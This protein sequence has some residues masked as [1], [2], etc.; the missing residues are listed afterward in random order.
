M[1]CNIRICPLP[2]LLGLAAVLA[3]STGVKAI[4]QPEF[5]Y[6]VSDELNLL[7]GFSSTAPGTLGSAVSLTGLAPGEQIRAIDYIGVTL[8][9]LGSEGHLYT[10]N[11]NTGAATAVGS[12]FSVPLNGVNFG[13][14]EASATGPLYVASDLGQNLRV[15]PTTGVATVLPGYTGATLDTLSYNHINNTYL[16]VSAVTHDL[17]SVNPVTGAETLI[18]A[19]GV[20]F[21][22]RI[23][24]TVSLDLPAAYFSGTIGG[25][26]GFYDLNP[27]T[28]ALA[29]VGDIGAPG[30]FTAGLDSITATGIILI[31]EPAAEVLLA[32]GGGFSL[33][34][35]RRKNRAQ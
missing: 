23:G 29:F 3:A 10:V 6:G 17:Y 22:D 21:L 34:L 35:L 18:G 14:A 8:Y 13:I 27:L 30:E 12:T 5:I 28:G 31:P 16:G 4:A 7:V 1:L 2:P 32:V 9:G 20:N 26:T 19:T 15:N 33:F 25:Q 11:P 24:L